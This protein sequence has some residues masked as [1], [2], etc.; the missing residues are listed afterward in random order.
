M[1]GP[2]NESG[3]S[4]VGVI[5]GVG[6]LVGAGVFVGV[7]VLVGEGVSVGTLVAVAVRLGKSD[8]VRD[9]MDGTAT[10]EV[11]SDSGC[12]SVFAG[13]SPAQLTA[14]KTK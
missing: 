12:R 13:V 7:A 5:V 6:V 3:G 9:C 1:R 4:G 10:C 2:R 8:G 11:N 14:N